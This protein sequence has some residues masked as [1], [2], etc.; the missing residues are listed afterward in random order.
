MLSNALCPSAEAGFYVYLKELAAAPSS[1]TALFE[2]YMLSCDCG[3]CWRCCLRGMA[4]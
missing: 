1:F 4:L 3:V 2:K